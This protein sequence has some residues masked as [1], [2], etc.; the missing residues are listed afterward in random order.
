MSSFHFIMAVRLFPALL[1]PLSTALQIP[2]APTRTIGSCRTVGVDFGLARVGVA[3][4]SGFAP[5]PLTVLPCGG[6]TPED[7]AAVASSV[8]R[9]CAG[10]GAVQVILGMPYNSTGGEGEQAAVT[11]AF[12]SCLADAVAPRP[13]FLWDERFS[14]QTASLRMN[15]GKGAARGQSVDAQAAAVILEDFFGA[16]EADA[17]A[18][19]H[20]PSTRSV[21]VG[22]SSAAPTALKR[23]PPASQSDVR[24][25]LMEKAARDEEQRGGD[26]GPGGSNGGGGAPRRRVPPIRKPSDAARR[27][28]FEVS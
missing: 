12:A 13:L 16:E 9:V 1:L 24:R 23:P 14:S 20:V 7:F 21:D 3:I 26:G 2:P 28:R 11:R 15:N 18:A 6:E 27:K 5:L 25:A 8:A 22:D 4:S 10:E 17:A 19:P